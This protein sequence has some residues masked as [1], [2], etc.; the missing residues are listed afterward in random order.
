MIKQRETWK[1]E[2]LAVDRTLFDQRDNLISV[3]QNLPDQYKEGDEDLLITQKVKTAMTKT[4]VAELTTRA[5]KEKTLRYYSA[6]TKWS[7]PVTQK[8][9]W[10]VCRSRP[11]TSVG[12]VNRAGK[13]SVIGDRT[14]DQT[15]PA[16]ERRLRR[17][18]EGAIDPPSGDRHRIDF[19]YRN[20]RILTYTTCISFFGTFW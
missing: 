6:F 11:A 4:R 17:L 19:S 2:Q 8:I 5:A 1:K 14:E 18:N 13:G 15:A 9:G 16:V 10:Q 20:D 12:L 3:K 7:A